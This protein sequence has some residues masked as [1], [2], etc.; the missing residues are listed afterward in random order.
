M[1][2]RLTFIRVS[3]P[4]IKTQGWINYFIGFYIISIS[5]VKNDFKRS[6]YWLVLQ[7]LELTL[8]AGCFY[9]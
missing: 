2:Q 4:I 9:Q 5:M 1:S 7:E 6:K 8:S 3:F